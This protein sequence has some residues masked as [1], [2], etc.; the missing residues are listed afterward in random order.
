MSFDIT[1]GE[2]ELEFKYSCKYYNFGAILSVLGLITFAGVIFIDNKFF[3]K[4]RLELIA[5][6]ADLIRSV[7]ENEATSTNEEEKEPSQS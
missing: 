2:H 6:N 5:E 7:E 1:P 4:K 3:K